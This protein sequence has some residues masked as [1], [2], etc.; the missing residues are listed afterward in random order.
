[1]AVITILVL[2]FI[3]LSAGMVWSFCE[4][5]YPRGGLYLLGLC[6]LMSVATVLPTVAPY[7]Y[8]YGAS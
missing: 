7:L 8:Q 6:S 5:D 4:Q 1:M 3:A 2:G